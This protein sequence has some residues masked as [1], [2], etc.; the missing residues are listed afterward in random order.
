M[1][2]IFK[3]GVDLMQTIITGT[4]GVIYHGYGRPFFGP[5]GQIIKGN[6]PFYFSFGGLYHPVFPHPYG[7]KYVYTGQ[8]MAAPYFYGLFQ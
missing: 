6:D 3:D 5:W 4:D 1:N 7:T 8:G 2:K